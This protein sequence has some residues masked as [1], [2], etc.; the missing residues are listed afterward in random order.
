MACQRITARIGHGYSLDG[1]PRLM[2]INIS[3]ALR[4]MASLPVSQP[5]PEVASPN[6]AGWQAA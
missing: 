6:Q 4:L 1:G 2:N 5:L 3:P